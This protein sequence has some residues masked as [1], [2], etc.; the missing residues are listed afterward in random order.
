M[1][2]HT[3]LTSVQICDVY[4]RAKHILNDQVR[5]M[6]GEQ[7][8]MPY[9]DNDFLETRM[10]HACAYINRAARELIARGWQWDYATGWQPT[11]TARW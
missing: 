3:S 5:T 9:E 10:D 8:R 6:S 4:Y 11:P 2:T 1:I 7:S